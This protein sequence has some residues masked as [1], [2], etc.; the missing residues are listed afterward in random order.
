MAPVAG[1]IADAEKDR[2]IFPSGLLK[3]L[4]SPGMPLYGVMR[5]LQE[6]RAGFV[7]ETVGVHFS[8]PTR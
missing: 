3:G 2:L 7:D 4:L 6:V 1:G 5:V 8:S